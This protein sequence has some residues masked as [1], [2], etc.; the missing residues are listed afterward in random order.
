ME[1]CTR[2]RNHYQRLSQP[3]NSVHGEDRASEFLEAAGY[4]IFERNWRCREGELDIIAYA[5]ERQALIGVE[6]KTRR[7]G[8]HVAAYE[9]VSA[10]KLARLR[11]LL[12]I[13]INE[14]GRHAENL[15]IDLIAISANEAGKS[16]LEHKEALL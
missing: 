7:I 1:T 3:A 10:R 14:S 8:G 2:L 9:A 15:A 12:I 16:L 5:P 6:V 13:W 11:R 4:R